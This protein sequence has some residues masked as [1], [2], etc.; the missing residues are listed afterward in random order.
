[1]LDAAGQAVGF[2]FSVPD[3]RDPHTVNLKTF[4]VTPQVR[5]TGMGAA[6][7]FEAYRR[8]QSKGYTRVNHCLMRSGN[9]ADQFD[10]GLAK[11]TRE[12][13]LYVKPM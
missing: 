2:S 4:G 10:R 1:M 8:F 9:R 12:Y 7:A 11:V 13:T 6:L 3:H 5:G